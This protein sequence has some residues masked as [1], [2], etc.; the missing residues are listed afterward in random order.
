[1]LERIAARL[2][3]RGY[4]VQNVRTASLSSHRM[5][6]STFWIHGGEALLDP[7][8]DRHDES[9]STQDRIIDKVKAVVFA[10][11]G[12]ADITP[13]SN[14]NRRR[15]DNIAKLPLESYSL[16][17]FGLDF[18]YPPKALA[19]LH[20]LSIAAITRD[21]NK[22]TTPCLPRPYS[23]LVGDSA[24]TRREAKVRKELEEAE[25][26]EED[27]DG[28]EYAWSNMG[29]GLMDRRKRRSHG[30]WQP[31]NAEKR[32]LAILNPMDFDLSDASFDRAWDW[33]YRK[34][35]AP[36]SPVMLLAQ[37]SSR[38]RMLL[39]YMGQSKRRIDYERMVE[40]IESI[41]PAKRRIVDHRNLVLSYLWLNQVQLALRALTQLVEGTVGNSHAGFE[42]FIRYSINNDMWDR[43]L[44]AW[45]LL[46]TDRAEIPRYK[47]VR[48]E[49]IVA[50]ILDFTRVY[51]AWV[52]NLADNDTLARDFATWLF[53]GVQRNYGEEHSIFTETAVESLSQLL[54]QK[55]W[56]HPDFHA[57]QY[58]ILGDSYRE[59]HETVVE[60]FLQYRDHPQA[61]PP[62]LLLERVLWA[63]IELGNFK[64]MQMVFDDWFKYHDH[65][66]AKAY[67][68]I[69]RA[70]AWRGE[71]A[72][73]EDLFHQYLE[74]FEPTEVDFGNILRAYVQR[75]ELTSAIE[76]FERMAEYK[77]QPDIHCYNV[78]LEGFAKAEDMDSA[79]EY[80]TLLLE[81]GLEPNSKTYASMMYVCAARG[82][83]ENVDILF[84]AAGKSKIMP[85]PTM[86]N[87]LVWAHVNGGA[88]SLAWKLIN[89]IHQQNFAFPLTHMYN[90]LMS[91]HANKK[92]L[93][94]VNKIYK[95]M[96]ARKVPFDIYT[97][98]IMMRALTQTQ[99]RSNLQK[100][101][102]MLDLLATENVDSD[103]TPYFTLM[104][105]Y[106][107]RRKYAE[108]FSIYKTMLHRKVSPDFGTQSLLLLA[109]IFEA[110][111][112]A[113][114]TGRVDL[115]NSEEISQLA[116]DKFSGLDPTNT[117]PIKSAIPD[118]MFTPLISAYIYKDDYEAVVKTYDKFLEAAS[119]N[120]VNRSKPSM[121]LLLKMMHASQRE[122]NWDGLRDLWKTTYKEAQ[123]RG[124][125][126][127][128]LSTGRSVVTVM[129]RELCPALD[130]MIRAAVDTLDSIDGIETTNGI[131]VD[132]IA[133][134]MKDMTEWGFDLDGGNWNILIVLL[135]KS[136]DL[137]QAF[138]I[139]ETQ[140]V[141]E[142]AYGYKIRKQRRYGFVGWAKHAQHPHLATLDLLASQ[143]NG[144]YTKARSFGEE[145]DKARDLLKEISTSY[146]II[147]KLTNIRRKKGPKQEREEMHEKLTDFLELAK[148]TEP[149][150][151]IKWE[152]TMKTKRVRGQTVNIPDAKSVESSKD[153]FR[154]LPRMEF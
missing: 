96:Q 149:A 139:A 28:Y 44:L 75:G 137:H 74:R 131:T 80:L 45:K 126:M 68:A 31:T 70:F 100:A 30:R 117:I 52:S 118:N 54:T 110:Q 73:C 154:G 72:I 114:Y 49:L 89:F 4:S 60:K 98:C 135:A 58:E 84:R 40:L 77:L 148:R 14:I 16:S 108:V 1:M 107:R 125:P 95:Q 112:L 133:T 18:L 42:E 6:H 143:L 145:A 103:T 120:G 3:R 20:R 115:R 99:H 86:W 138:K 142:E 109:S 9:S 56:Y 102:R 10:L 46:Q 61:N 38:R 32:Y 105:A 146:P 35:G 119:R 88:R 136:G 21:G 113:K 122:G 11:A 141:R 63:T 124:R 47:E 62:A 48:P 19:L 36:R 13:K 55:N 37:D 69:M 76:R 132:E 59:N 150:M 7:Y 39:G 90:M 64:V 66:N 34:K 121:N 101:R 27:D 71:A 87:M 106:L 128:E 82:D 104:Q 94:N 24:R 29:Y 153:A 12:Q 53:Y 8:L 151:K 25:I 22:R 51:T 85:S 116:I 43:A 15:S 130:I 93:K 144:L 111:E 41:E 67:R 97:Y 81:T 92:E 123:R 79:M 91:A 127:G 5:L 83:F 57:F 129:K 140:L 50:E 134:I 65:P 78:L 2:N 147:F 23:S 17:A 152:Y 33:Y 26:L